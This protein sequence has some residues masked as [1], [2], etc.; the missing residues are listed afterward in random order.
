MADYDDSVIIACASIIVA[1]VGAVAIISRVQH[2]RKRK[3]KVWIQK[4]IKQREQYGA[5]YTLL[6]ELSDSA[7]IHAFLRMD[8]DTFEQL[9][10]LVEPEIIRKRTRL[11]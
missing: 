6:P 7:K 2:K 10:L 3:H 9:F 5:Y 4:Y 8:K 11:R 1:S